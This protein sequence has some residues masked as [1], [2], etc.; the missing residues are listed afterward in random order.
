M[1][2]VAH[3]GKEDA[4][5]QADALRL[6][7]AA[8]GGNEP[9][10]SLLELRWRRPGGPMLQEWW[11]VRAHKSI[12]ERVRALASRGDVYVGATPR[13]RQQG[14][15]DAVHRG[16]AL[17]TDLDEP[18][19]LDRLQAVTPA[20]SIVLL[21][22]SPGH[23]LAIWPLRTALAPAHL[24]RANRRLAR[25]LAG[26]LAATDAARIVRVPQTANHKHDPPVAVRC[27]RLEIAV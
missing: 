15:K 9:V 16:W 1:T 12:A 10:G 13:V 4:I 6:Q 24:V 8:L 22:G 19:A 26:D 17:W 11:P 25:A 18:D 7:I 14:T 3:A 27:V 5:P 2:V 23:A 21:T 20:P